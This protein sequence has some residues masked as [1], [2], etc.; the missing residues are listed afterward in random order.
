MTDK[1][2]TVIFSLNGNNGLPDRLE[3]FDDF[4]AAEDRVRQLGCWSGEPG[5]HQGSHTSAPRCSGA[6][7]PSWV[8]W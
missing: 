1:D 4:N 5:I 7:W 6:S 3:A 2:Q 8:W